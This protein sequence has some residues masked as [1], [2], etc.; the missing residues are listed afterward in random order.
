MGKRAITGLRLEKRG[1]V[2]IPCLRPAGDGRARRHWRLEISIFR[3][4]K[5]RRSAE[6]PLRGA[7]GVALDQGGGDAADAVGQDLGADHGGVDAPAQHQLLN[8]LQA[9]QVQAQMTAAGGKLGD[10]LAGVPL[11][12]TDNVSGPGIEFDDDLVVTI[13]LHDAEAATQILLRTENEGFQKALVGE[14][15]G[16][17]AAQGEGAG[18]VP[19]SVVAHEVPPV[20]NVRDVVG[21]D[22]AT[23]SGACAGLAVLENQDTVLFE[24]AGDDAEGA[25]VGVFRGKRPDGEG[26]L[27]IVNGIALGGVQLGDKPLEGFFEGLLERGAPELGNRFIGDEHAEEVGLADG[28]RH[29]WEAFDRAGVEEA[30]AEA[31]VFD[32][33]PEVA[34]HKGQVAL[35]GLER[36]F[37]AGGEGVAVW[38]GA[39]LDFIVNGGK[40]PG[41]LAPELGMEVGETV[42]L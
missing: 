1:W 3:G 41:L 24:G 20:F 37:E 31:V 2:S 7:G 17:Q 28:C 40:P 22:A 26:C 25:D 32:G 36:D 14:A 10:L 33:E 12:P 5:W 4:G 13:A 15:R 23:F 19:G 8:F 30:A 27:K 34:P 11:A 9:A 6:A 18:G 38:V 35:D 21:V 16:A 42:R 29:A 39:T